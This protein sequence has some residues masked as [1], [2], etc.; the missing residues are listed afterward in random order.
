[1]A[2]SQTQTQA[3][4]GWIP[5]TRRPDGTWRKARRVKEGYVPPDEA[6]K[7]E[8]KGKQWLKNQSNVPPGASETEAI[9]QPAKL[10]KNQKKNERKKAKKKQ[11]GE[12]NDNGV[13][14]VTAGVARFDI[15]IV[16]AVCIYKVELSQ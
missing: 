2:D 6:E 3:E 14:D 7:Y 11:E 5:A 13:E 4:S 12:T 8:S 1:M 16:S 15:I 10:T 9:K